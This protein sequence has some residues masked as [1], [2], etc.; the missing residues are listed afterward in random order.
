MDGDA[1]DAHTVNIW[2]ERW[3]SLHRQRAPENADLLCPLSTLL[4]GEEGF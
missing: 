3:T 4:Y 1:I 2:P